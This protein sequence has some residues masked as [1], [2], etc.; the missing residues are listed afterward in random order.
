MLPSYKNRLPDSGGWNP[1]G[2]VSSRPA[3]S[4]LSLALPVNPA[5]RVGMMLAQQLKAVGVEGVHWQR[6]Q[7]QKF[8][9][10]IARLVEALQ[11]G[12]VRLV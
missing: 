11:D 12:G 9:G 10:R 8:H 3:V 4:R 6:K 2:L 7:G 1:E 5:R